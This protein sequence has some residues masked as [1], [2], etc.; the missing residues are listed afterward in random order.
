MVEGV[1]LVA[2][3]TSVL[4]AD[5]G[6]LNIGGGKEV[7]VSIKKKKFCPSSGAPAEPA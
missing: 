4:T 1:K 5:T 7:V 3:T 6:V 2:E